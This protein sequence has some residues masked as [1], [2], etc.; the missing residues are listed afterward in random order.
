M[1]T[2]SGNPNPEI[3][4][5]ENIAE[6]GKATQFGQPGAPDP[7]AAAKKKAA[8]EPARWSYRGHFKNLA[9]QDISTDPARINEELQR[10]RDELGP[11]AP[12]AKMMAIRALERALKKMEPILLEKIIDNTEGKLSQTIFTP[13]KVIAEENPSSLEEAA[14]IYNE[15]V[16]Q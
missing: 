9:A 10:L 13:D 11:K 5:N 12:L 8:E 15:T 6:A 2:N 14:R 7:V 4:I 1:P 3:H 16:A